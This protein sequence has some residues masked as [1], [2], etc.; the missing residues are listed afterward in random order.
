MDHH[1]D[2]LAED[3]DNAMLLAKNL[4]EIDGINLNLA[5][6]ETNLVFFT[7]DAELGT[8]VQLS[9]KLREQGIFIGPMG[10][11]RMRA[12]THL[13]ISTEDIGTIT[14][15][16]REACSTGFREYAVVGAGPYDK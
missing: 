2:R 4:N 16:I 9:G 6:V 10:G 15:A 1:V 5:D 12:C 11:Q 3:H 14:D 7:I 8:A 13:D